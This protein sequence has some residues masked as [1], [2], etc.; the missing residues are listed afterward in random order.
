MPFMYHLLAGLVLVCMIGGLLGC[1]SAVRPSIPPP[2]EG[3]A[4]YSGLQAGDSTQYAVV[5]APRPADQ[6]AL[7]YLQE[8]S[9]EIAETRLSVVSEDS[10]FGSGNLLSLPGQNVANYATKDLYVRPGVTYR[11]R[12]EH[13]RDTVTGTTQVPGRF[14]VT[15]ENLTIRWTNSEGA[16]RY[17]VRVQSTGD[18]GHQVWNYEA[19]TST[20]SVVVDTSADAEAFQEGVHSVVVAAVDSNLTRYRE[21]EPERTGLN[22]GFGF[23]GSVTRVGTRVPLPATTDTKH[24]HP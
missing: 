15:A 21:E 16:Q 8:A 20:R 19:T 23:F 17:R 24:S 22:K 11:L 5:G 2:P 18:E 10:I 4:I 6:R 3:I 1:D 12:V 13:E 14:K 9:V 7:R